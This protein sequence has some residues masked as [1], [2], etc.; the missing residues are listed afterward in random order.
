MCQFFLRPVASVLSFQ[1][2]PSEKIDQ[3]QAAA[4]I[5]GVGVGLAIG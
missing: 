5:E 4:E 3:R 2:D 1:T